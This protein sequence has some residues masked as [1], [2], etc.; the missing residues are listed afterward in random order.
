MTKKGSNDA[1]GMAGNRSRNKSGPLREKRGDTHVGT[2]EKEYGVDFGVRSD[3]Q[4]DTLLEKEN[5]DSL[6]ELLRKK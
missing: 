6:K 1:P 3:M 4:L 2:I 5:V